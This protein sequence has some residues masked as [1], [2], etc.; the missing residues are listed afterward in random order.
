MKPQFEESQFAVFFQDDLSRR[1]HGPIQLAPIGQVL[2][3]KVGF[4]L[5]GWV[6]RAHPMWSV[7]HSAP[8]PG[9]SRRAWNPSLDQTAAVTSK[10]LNVFFQFKRPH[11]LYRPNATYF[12]N[13]GGPYW[14]F[15]VDRT[16]NPGSLPQ[17]EMLEQLEMRTAGF[18][19]VRY[20]SPICHTYAKLEAL[21]DSSA[22]LEE[23]VYVAPTRFAP[24]HTTCA[25]T[26]ATSMIVNPD[27][28]PTS[29]DTWSDVHG[30]LAEMA[31]NAT[32]IDELIGR[33]GEVARA[34]GARQPDQLRYPWR[35]PRRLTPETRTLLQSYLPVAELL[36][37]NRLEWL[38]AI[39]PDE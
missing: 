30:T 33:T 17:H 6:P 35:L 26:S 1:K 8:L 14:R 25:Y 13:L 20:V 16:E 18:G 36:F 38:V 31:T 9:L 24:D 12:A 34:L 23:C 29:A 4:D 5:G 10:A 3:A 11:H 39:A 21:C 15:Y 7:L 2:E 19:V 27:P 28:E 37:R 22:L 32:D